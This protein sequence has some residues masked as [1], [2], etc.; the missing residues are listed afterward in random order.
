VDEPNGATGDDIDIPV[1]GDIREVVGDVEVVPNGDIVSGVSVDVIVVAGGIGLKPPGASSV[2][3]IGTPVRPTAAS[4]PIPVGDDA[5]A[6]GLDETVTP[7]VE[8][9][10]D[11]VPELPPPSKSAVGLDKPAV[12]VALA[13]LPQAELLPLIVPGTKLLGGA[14]LMPGEAN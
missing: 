12:I 2:E 4:A 11:A 6:A 7:V 9:V 14:G 10:P 1:E 5:D 13:E 8:H 3:P